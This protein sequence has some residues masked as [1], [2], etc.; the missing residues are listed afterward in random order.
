MPGIFCVVDINRKTNLREL[1]SRMAKAIKHKDWHTI[2]SYSDRERNVGLGR[3]DTGILNPHPQPIFN[4]DGSLAIVMEGEIFDYQNLKEELIK[5]GHYFKINN[6]PEFVLHLYEEIGEDFVK[7]LNGFFAIVIWHRKSSRLVVANDRFGFRSLYYTFVKG[8]LIFC[9]E[10][11]G[12]LQDKCVKKN[13]DESGVADFFAFG[14]LLGDKTLFK[15]IKLLPP[16]SLWVYQNG[17][18]MRKHYWKLQE[19]FGI[20]KGSEDDFL[21][22]ISILLKQAVQRQTTGNYDFAVSLTGGLDS[23]TIFAAIDHKSYPVHSFTHG[24]KRCVDLEIAE[25]VAKKVGSNRHHS[26]ELGKEFLKKFLDYTRETVFLTDGMAKLGLVQMLYSRAK[27]R[28]YAQIELSAGGADLTRGWGLKPLILTSKNNKEV[29]KNCF[30]SYKTDFDDKR[31]FRKSFYRRIGGGP[32][33]SLEALYSNL[34]EDFL[35]KDKANYFYILEHIRKLIMNGRTLSGNYIELRLP[36]WDNDLI[37]LIIKAPLKLL[38]F[39][40]QIPRFV[41]KKNNPDLTAVPVAD[42]NYIAPFYDSKLRC[43]FRYLKDIFDSYTK[44]YIYP[45]LPRQTKV[46][47]F[48]KPYIDYDEWMRNELRGFVENT[49]LDSRTLDRGYYNPGYVKQ[50]VSNHMTRRRNLSAILNLMIGLELWHRLFID[51]EICRLPEESKLG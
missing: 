5:K 47:R 30:E 45:F 38:T 29:I 44:M 51:N 3:V 10:I 15:D 35:P 12:I 24:I 23:R 21:E 13:I 4:E 19:Q 39:Q 40:R 26:Y 46:L 25:K 2:H 37:D 32:V 50:M 42:N 20:Y 14:H 8:R 17:R 6:D 34:N 27:V 31:L 7:K 9:S 48:A 11:K 22:E 36:Y 49:L 43:G 1:T 33:A 28:G 18:L 16:A 41:V